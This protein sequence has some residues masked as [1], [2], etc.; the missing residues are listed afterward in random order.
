MA[1]S[2]QHFQL[3]RHVVPPRRRFANIAKY[4]TPVNCK[5]FEKDSRKNG[6][7]GPAGARA[8]EPMESH[9]GGVQSEADRRAG[10]GGVELIVGKKK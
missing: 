3:Q 4:C 10:A 9:A 2:T 6:E 7:I 1:I 8:L 5:E